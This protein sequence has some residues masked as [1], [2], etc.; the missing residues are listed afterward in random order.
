MG[1]PIGRAISTLLNSRRGELLL[2]T[3]SDAPDGPL[4]AALADVETFLMGSGAPIK[5]VLTLFLEHGVGKRRGGRHQQIAALLRWLLRHATLGS[6]A[7]TS[8]VDLLRSDAHLN[9]LKLSAVYALL[10]ALPLRR[11]SVWTPSTIV[12]LFRA[13]LDVCHTTPSAAPS[14]LAVAS[15]DVAVCCLAELCRSAAVTGS[16]SVDDGCEDASQEAETLTSISSKAVLLIERLCAWRHAQP[17]FAAATRELSDAFAMRCCGLGAATLFA[18]CAP[19]LLGEAEQTSSRQRDVQLEGWLLQLDAPAGAS[20][21][22]KDASGEAC[23]TAA[24]AAGRSLSYPTRLCGEDEERWQARVAHQAL[25]CLALQIDTLEP[26]RRAALLARSH[27]R[28]YPL[29]SGR[30]TSWHEAALPLALLDAILPAM[31]A[32][33]SSVISRLQPALDV[34]QATDVASDAALAAMA[35]L[36]LRYHEQ[37]IPDVCSKVQS[38]LEVQRANAMNVLLRLAELGDL[39]RLLGRLSTEELVRSLVAGIVKAEASI[40]CSGGAAGITACGTADKMDDQMPSGA[41]AAPLS[42]GGTIVAAGSTLPFRLLQRVD[43][44]ISLPLLAAAARENEA[45]SERQ[46]AANAA[47]GATRR[48]LETAIAAAL[49]GPRDAAITIGAAIDAIRDASLP[50]SE[51]ATAASANGRD[52]ACVTSPGQIGPMA[53]ATRPTSA[54]DGGTASLGDAAAKAA[55]AGTE[56][57]MRAIDTWSDS[58]PA[59][60]WPRAFALAATKFFAA[61]QDIGSLHVLKRMLAHTARAPGLQALAV[62]AAVARI[63]ILGAAATTGESMPYDR[64]RPLLLLQMLPEDGWATATGDGAFASGDDVDTGGDAGTGGDAS[65]GRDVGVLER[66]LIPCK[67]ALHARFADGSELQPVRKM[68]ASLLARLPPVRSGLLD[69][70]LALVRALGVEPHARASDPSSA[71]ALYYLCCAATLH[72]AAAAAVGERETFEAI[73]CIMRA[74]AEPAAVAAATEATAASAAALSNASSLDRLRMGCVELL[75]RVWC[76]ELDDAAACEVPRGA[77]GIAPLAATSP[78]VA[79]GRTNIEARILTLLEGPTTSTLMLMVCNVAMRMRHA[80]G[81]AT[82][83][84]TLAGRVLPALLPRPGPHV[85]QALFDLAFHAQPHLSPESLS[86]LAERVR[87]DA[88]SASEQMRMAAL[89]L[90]GVVLSAAVTGSDGS[91]SRRAGADVDVASVTASAAAAGQPAVV[92]VEPLLR[93]LHQLGT[94]DTSD[95]V[96][97]LSQQLMHTAF[98]MG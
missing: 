39:G 34:L 53:R 80:R 25:C 85:T 30:C 50:A 63:G 78:S 75:A 46:G 49:S 8:L 92:D 70:M 23:I 11:A 97:R 56:V 66:Q 64:L 71:L 32:D 54:A 58:L 69:E 9:R 68:A 38:P 90:A 18:S 94:S 33:G 3:G 15:A 28:L 16:S 51:V 73:T 91:V 81:G 42:V 65:V 60:E 93:L 19:L 57:L 17:L 35:H 40:E 7:L 79:A 45:C 1:A 24:A 76:A 20:V 74:P 43:P 27:G 55:E 37:L 29:L 36:A 82:L 72:P 26:P 31:L 89:K 22:D 4:A 77:D 13:T 61:S 41:V 96:R 87:T 52:V 88:H 10:E 14:V 48:A 98:G 12:E 84:A 59:D 2:A 21:V 6:E 62:Q 44:H 5:H 47:A 95:D 86:G 83:A 67:N